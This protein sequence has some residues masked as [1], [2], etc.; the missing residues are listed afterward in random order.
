MSVKNNIPE[1][2]KG[3]IPKIQGI[4]K[5]HCVARGAAFGSRINGGY[6]DN[7]DLDIII[8]FQEGTKKILQHILSISKE[9]KTQCGFIVDITTFKGV[10][11][12]VWNDI[13]NSLY[14]FY[15]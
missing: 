7:S 12:K 1:G 10:N 6:D 5:K 2:M 9:I 15:E 3:S 13:E 4:L 8:E 11:K 14:F